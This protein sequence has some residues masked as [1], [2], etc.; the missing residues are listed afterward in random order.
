MST[1]QDILNILSDN[2]GAF[3]SGQEIAEKLNVSRNAIWKAIEKLKEDG[4]PVE[5]KA[6][7]GYRLKKAFDFL[8]EDIIGNGLDF[9]CDLIVK[10]KVDSTNALAKKQFKDKVK[11]LPQ[12]GH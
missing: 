3:V 6:R 8:S 5:S 1:K 11:I 9:E 4:L 12:T 2:I 7:N 10:D